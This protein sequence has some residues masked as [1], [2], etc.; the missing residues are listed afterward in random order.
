MKKAKTR[1]SSR[2]RAW[3]LLP[4]AAAAAAAL[5]FLE[6][7]FSLPGSEAVRF[8]VG[9]GADSGYLYSAIRSAGA[10]DSTL[11]LRLVS[12]LAN[13]RCAVRPGVYEIRP[14]DTRW[15]VISNLRHG[16]IAT[17]RFRIPDGF[18]FARVKERLEKDSGIV[19]GT[20]EEVVAA[21]SANSEAADFWRFL[22]P[23]E[24]APR[25]S[26]EG[27]L[28]PDTYF[29]NV[30]QSDSA[31]LLKALLQQKKVFTEEWA[32]RDSRVD[33]VL[34]TPYDALKL[35]SII[36]KESGEKADRH[37]VASVF[38]NRL[39]I[40]MPLQT[41]P[42]VIYGAGAA[43]DGNLR[44]ADLRRDNPY[45]TYTRRGLPPTPI[46]APSRE[47]IRAALHPADTKYLYFVAR[48][49]GTTQFS[50]T[51]KDHNAAVDEYQ[52]KA[53]R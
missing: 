38:F 46:S 23:G 45:N 52:R 21:L 25:F 13:F 6:S 2:S 35:A 12:A 11:S 18:A 33:A 37:L 26:P 36:E 34:R 51:L 9:K 41:D 22:N 14:G 16:V 42:T 27:L 3:L 44:K 43:F 7:G 20:A 30:G 28:A 32:S 49:D 53:K 24:D 1:K 17:G 5:C 50:E 47:S 19:S 31:V 48:G 15:R 29:Y 8:Q 10:S 40:G 39:R 4:A